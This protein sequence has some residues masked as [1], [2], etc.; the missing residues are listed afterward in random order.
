MNGAGFAPAGPVTALSLLPLPGSPVI[1]QAAPLP[2]Q[3]TLS[4]DTPPANCVPI[5]GYQDQLDVRRYESLTGV[6]DTHSNSVANLVGGASY[7]FRH[8]AVDPIEEVESSSQAAPIHGGPP[9]APGI[10]NDMTGGEAM[11]NSWFSNPI[12]A[13]GPPSATTT[14]SCPRASQ[15]FNERTS[16]HLNQSLF[17]RGL[18]Y[19]IPTPS[20]GSCR[21]AHVGPAPCAGT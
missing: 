18:E 10:N 12:R 15:P 3:I 21:H 5:T 9:D 17:L 7:G 2:E 11:T 4:W 20:T 8:C 16:R 14:C 19:S 6:A 1:V 13:D